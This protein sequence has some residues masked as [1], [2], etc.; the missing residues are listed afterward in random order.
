[1]RKM[2]LFAT[3]AAVLLLNTFA[4]GQV[5]LNTGYNHSAFSAYLPPAPVSTT[6]D[7]YWINIASYPT[8]PTAPAW[9][10]QKAGGWAFAFPNTNWIGPRTTFASA[11]G[12]NTENPSYTIFR[13]CFCLLPGYNSVKLS[14]SQIRADDTIQI[15]L[16]S[17]V[18][19]VLAPSW[20]N[21]NGVPLS[22]GTSNGFHV[23]KNC[24]YVLVEDYYGGAMGFDL[25]GSVQGNGVLPLPAAGVGQSFEPCACRSQGSVG[26]DPRRTAELND[27]DE[28]VIRELV[29]TAESRRAEK[30][31]R[32]FRGTPTKQSNNN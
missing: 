12:T 8:L 14:L 5:V 16:N 10:I 30:Q 4:F 24:V 28:Q 3:F 26:P 31:K 9:V 6:Q 25:V 19:Q 29:K 2:N 32:V 15:W 13:K 11:T 23:G 20:G 27:N 18:N 21:L 7:Q 1:M 17:Q 22:A